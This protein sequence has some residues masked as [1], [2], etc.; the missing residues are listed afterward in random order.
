MVLSLDHAF[1]EELNDYF[2]ELYTDNTYMEPEPLE[3][4]N[5]HIIPEIT[6]SQAWKSL[7]QR[8]KT[9]AGPDGIPY[10]VWKDY[11]ALLAPVITMVWNLS[12]KTLTWRRAWKKSNV[13]PLPKVD[14]PKEETNYRGINVT[15]VIARAFEKIVLRVH[16]RDIM[17]EHLSAT[18]F[19]YREGGSCTN[20]LLSI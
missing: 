18:Q 10:T 12:L 7:Q 9:A 5:D 14:I 13:I 11:G 2:G 20:V 19:T 16:A 3:I 17:E 1:L 15:S 4:G 8:R 6:E